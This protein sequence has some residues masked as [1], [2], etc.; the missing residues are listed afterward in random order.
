MADKVFANGLRFFPK[1]EKAP[2]WVLGTLVITPNDLVTWLKDNPQYLTDYKGA[3]QLKIQ[4]AK[5]QNG[6]INGSVDTWKPDG[7]QATAAQED[8]GSDLPF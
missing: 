7:K 5:S 2:D 4:I 1:H 8:A 3:K 6:G